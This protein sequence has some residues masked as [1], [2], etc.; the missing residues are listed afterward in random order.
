LGVCEIDE[1]ARSTRGPRAWE[2][3]VEVEGRDNDEGVSNGYGNT[4]VAW[5]VSGR[6]KKVLSGPTRA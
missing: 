1:T 2:T 6:N 4:Y 5:D 3:E